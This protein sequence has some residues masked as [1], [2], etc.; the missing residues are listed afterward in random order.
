MNLIRSNGFRNVCGTIGILSETPWRVAVLPST[1]NFMQS[2]EVGQR[3]L[4]FRAK[5]TFFE[6]N[7][8]S[9]ETGT[10]EL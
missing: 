2:D 7:K 1:A 4:I 5:R 8:K 6:K 9:G 3:E 10:Q